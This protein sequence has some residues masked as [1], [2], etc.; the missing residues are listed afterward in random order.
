M[1]PLHYQSAGE[2]ATELRQGRISSVELTRHFMD[3]ARRS[4]GSLNAVT[5]LD[6]GAI[7][8]AGQADAA[9]ARGVVRGPLH[10]LP[11]LLK[12]CWISREMPTAC[13]VSR[14]KDNI[15]GEN[16]PVV[17]RLLDAGVIIMGRTNV[18]SFCTDLQTF[19]K[20][21]GITNNPWNPERTAGGS[22][23]GAAA[24]VAAGLTPFELGSDLAGSL[25]LVNVERW[26]GAALQGRRRD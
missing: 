10:G 23:G 25:Q 26:D 17:Q 9:L 24:A 19:N 21:F 6:E 5:Y 22:S 3:R 12:D 1:K 16:A 18:P 11:M 13:G 7:D 15:A 4:A 8:R 14:L 2:L 20:P